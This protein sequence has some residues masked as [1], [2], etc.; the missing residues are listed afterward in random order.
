MR[1]ERKEIVRSE[2]EDKERVD[3]GKCNKSGEMIVGNKEREEEK[4]GKRRRCRTVS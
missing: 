3:R 2:Y 4:S 1:K